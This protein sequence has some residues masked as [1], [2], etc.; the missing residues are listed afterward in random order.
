MQTG[1]HLRLL[2]F[3]VDRPVNLSVQRVVQGCLPVNNIKQYKSIQVTV[4][5]SSWYLH[6]HGKTIWMWHVL[7]SGVAVCGVWEE[8]V[9]HLVSDEPGWAGPWDSEDGADVG[10][11]RRLH[12]RHRPLPPHAART[13]L[14]GASPAPPSLHVG[15]RQP[16]YLIKGNSI[17]CNFNASLWGQYLIN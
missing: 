3:L 4:C 6:N 5:V 15:R 8:P 11:P 10:S 12:P 9:W 17:G 2:C 13:L 14:Q 16:G 7:S 1:S